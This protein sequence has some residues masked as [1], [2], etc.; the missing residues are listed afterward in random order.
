MAL[1]KLDYY[2]K[3]MRVYED[4]ESQRSAR[5]KLG[6]FLDDMGFKSQDFKNSNF[7]NEELKEAKINDL[8]NRCNNFCK[9]F[10]E[11]LGSEGIDECQDTLIAYFESLKEK[12]KKGKLE[13]GTVKNRKFTVKRLVEKVM[14][15]KD[16]DW[17][18][19][20][21]GLPRPSRFAQDR[22][23]SLE[24]IRQICKY[25][26]PRIK[27]IVYFFVSSGVRL[28]AWDYLKW[29]HISPQTR[30]NKL[31]CALVEVYQ[32]TDEQY[33]TLITAETY[34]TL[35]EWMDFRENSGE[36]ITPDSC[37][38]RDYW[39][40]EEGFTHG[41]A[42]EP[43]RLKSSGIKSLIDSAVRRQGL[44][45]NL[46]DGK[47]R[48]EVQLN[49]SFRKFHETQLIKANLKQVDINILQGHANEGMID[50][51]YR[52]SSDP[53]NRIDDYL[54]NEFLK[55][56]KFLIIDEVIRDVDKL[57]EEFKKELTA[58]IKN[59]YEQQIKELR[60]EMLFTKFS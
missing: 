27:P 53:N 58:E 17:E 6:L 3:F 12:I 37:L 26:D 29:G 7:K 54:I 34:N 51:Y 46:T 5:S 21:N 45:K 28:G 30:N 24:E 23:Y 1:A 36:I 18:E 14:N 22:A 32:G 40:T 48:H 4:G 60:K 41:M 9:E 50:H 11:K 25:K 42:R 35:K 55:A 56:E 19:V 20:F 49:H 38:M 31:V 8:R 43:E 59:N 15:Y 2:D 44:R 33:P 47:K 16:F 13:G 52:P 57:K 39:D 10:K